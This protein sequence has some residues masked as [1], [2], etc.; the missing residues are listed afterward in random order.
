[1]A[2]QQRSFAEADSVTRDRLSPRREKQSTAL[3]RPMLEAVRLARDHGDK[4]KRFPGGFWTAPQW[5][6]AR[7]F[8]TPTI[9]ALVKRGYAEY[10]EWVDGRSGRFPVEI[11]LKL[12]VTP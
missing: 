8:G 4:L 6:I 3:S 10:T 5:G 7:T 2:D 11:T 1:V 12:R 9:E